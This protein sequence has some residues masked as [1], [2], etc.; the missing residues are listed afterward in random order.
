[1]YL[2]SHNRRHKGNTLYQ[3]HVSS[4]RKDRLVF[5]PETL[6]QR[7]RNGCEYASPFKLFG[8]IPRFLLQAWLVRVLHAISNLQSTPMKKSNIKVSKKRIYTRF[9]ELHLLNIGKTNP[10]GV[11]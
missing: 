8:T 10:R 6:N 7:T 11:L 9:S 5:R 3:F 2:A 4:Y 1:M